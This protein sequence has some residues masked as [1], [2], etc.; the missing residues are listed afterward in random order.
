MTCNSVRAMMTER[1][2]FANKYK[3][4]L[5]SCTSLNVRKWEILQAGSDKRGV[6]PIL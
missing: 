4:I 3:T 1:S 6:A 5:P 2:V